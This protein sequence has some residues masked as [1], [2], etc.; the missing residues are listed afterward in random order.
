VRV[1]LITP[2]HI[3]T[4][5]RIV[6]EADALS[7]AVYDVT[8]IAADYMPWGRQADAEFSG[9]PWRVVHKVP[10]GPRAPQPVYLRQTLTRFG[11]RALV[12][13]AGL[14]QSLVEGTIHPAAPDLIRAALS[15]RADLY[16]A[17]YTAALP[18]AA[19]AAKKYGALYAFDAEDYH[20]GD[21]PDS[22]D[23]YFEKSLIRTI[24]ER[25]LPGCA[26]MTAASPGIADAYASTY[27]LRRP[28]VVL[29][30]FPRENAPKEPTSAGTVSPG[31]SLY[32]FSQ[33]IGPNRGLE[34]AAE[35]I[36]LSAARPHLYVRGTLAAGFGEVLRSLA[37]QFDIAD[38]IHVL[39]PAPPSQM[40]RLA[41]AYDVGLAGEIGETPNHR[42]AL[43]NKLFSYLL[44]GIP[45]VASAIPA[46]RALDDTEGAVFL[47]EPLDATSLAHSLDKLLCDPQQLVQARNRAWQLGQQRYNW[48]IEKHKFLSMLKDLRIAGNLNRSKALVS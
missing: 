33:T 10:F 11:A 24:E 29:N 36:C 46:H 19:R 4:N 34:V 22:P 45:A 9:R 20:L 6:K 48:D 13:A 43:S 40:E 15:V 1:C 8:V 5:P 37:N 47:Y 16:I 27:G 32:W 41:S 14:H 31:P 3:S 26:Y 42:I 25:Y 21:L 23:C 39:E 28:T 38:R 17:H 7:E 30:V 18:A 2:G 35:A 12:K 44:A